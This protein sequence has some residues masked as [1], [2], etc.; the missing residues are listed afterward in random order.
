MLQ[1]DHFC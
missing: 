1:F